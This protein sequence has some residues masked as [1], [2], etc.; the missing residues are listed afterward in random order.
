MS[1]VWIGA[2]PK[3]RDYVTDV[4]E[5]KGKKHQSGAWLSAFCFSEVWHPLA[6]CILP[7]QIPRQRISPCHSVTFLSRRDFPGL[8]CSM[9]PQTVHCYWGAVLL[10]SAGRTQCPFC[11]LLPASPPLLSDFLFPPTCSFVSVLYVQVHSNLNAVMY[12]LNRLCPLVWIQFYWNRFSCDRSPRPGYNK[13]AST[14]QLYLFAGFT[15]CLF[16]PFNFQ[17]YPVIYLLAYLVL[18]KLSTSAL[19]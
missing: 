10:A 17:H 8:I 19:M 2:Q 14:A 3:E 12:I 5:G 1:V 6:T 18:A 7:S 16:L 13:R 9:F 11:Y 15:Y 4:T